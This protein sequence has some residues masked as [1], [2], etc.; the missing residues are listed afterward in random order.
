MSG[1]KH[2]SF[3]RAASALAEILGVNKPSDAATKIANVSLNVEARLVLAAWTLRKSKSKNLKP[4]D[5]KAAWPE[6]ARER[7]RDYPESQTPFAA[8]LSVR[9]SKAAVDD[10]QP[11]LDMMLLI[12]DIPT[13]HLVFWAVWH[14]DGEVGPIPWEKVRGSLGVN[15]S[16]W[17]FK[18]RYDGALQEI[19]SKYLCAANVA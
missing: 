9:S 11:A 10:E 14:Q 6:I 7:G 5:A 17:T 15:M 2:T 1:F 19:T 4:A 18:R 12:D 3:E 8:R 16:R 13:R